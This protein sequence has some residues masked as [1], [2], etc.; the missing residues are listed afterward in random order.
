[1]DSRTKDTGKR[2]ARIRKHRMMSQ[3]ALAEAIGVTRSVISNIERGHT[4]IDLDM[5]ERLAP[6]LHCT[7]SGLR[8]P[9]DAPLPWIRSRRRSRYRDNWFRI[10]EL[11]V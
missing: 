5:A 6:A 3:T 9:L 2:I 8:A 11:K 10:S 1:M 4:R 7:V